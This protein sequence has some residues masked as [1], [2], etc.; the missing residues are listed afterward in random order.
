MNF[1]FPDRKALCAAE[2]ASH[3]LHNILTIRG[4]VVRD[5]HAWAHYLTETITLWGKDLDLV[6]ASHHWPTWGRAR[7]NEYLAMQRDMY[8]YLHDQTLRMINQGYVG[9]EIAEVLEMPPALVAAWHT[10]GYYGT[11]SHNIKAIYQRY[12]GWYEGNP[13]RLWEHPPAESARRYVAAMGGSDAAV[14]IAQKAFDEGDYRWSAQVLDHVLFADEAHPSARELQA[15]TFEQL[16]FQAESGTW[17]SAYLAGATELRYGQ[18][19]TPANPGAPDIL[20]ALTVSQV[21]DSIAIRID[22]PRAWDAYVSLSWVI[23]DEDSVYTTELRNGVLNHH[24]VTG[25]MDGATA[26]RLTR[27]SLIGVLTGQLDLA[28]ALADGTVGVVGNPADL[29]VLVSMLA[30]V[31]PDFAIV[32]P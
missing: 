23:T 31:D 2:N 28:A 10:H 27:E 18:F 3:T 12:L 32:T 19:G 16:G 14:A 5:A 25:P 17:R 7:V 11:V 13:A 24:K 1:Y 15:A 26:F 9:S 22:G 4:A 6:F 29:H 8:L 20:G 30:P 21:F